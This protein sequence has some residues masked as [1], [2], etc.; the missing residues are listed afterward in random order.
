MDFTLEESLSLGDKISSF[1]FNQVN[2]THEH[3]I[4]NLRACVQCSIKGNIQSGQLIIFA[5]G[6]WKLSELK[7]WNT[8][9]KCF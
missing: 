7:I 3:S 4:E 5:T 9:N 2:P 1:V 6:I 8:I